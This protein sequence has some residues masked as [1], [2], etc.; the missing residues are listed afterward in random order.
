M[1][2]SCTHVR[3]SSGMPP[4]ME[5]QKSPVATSSPVGRANPQVKSSDSLKMVE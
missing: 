4:I 1:S 5:G 3:S 2:I